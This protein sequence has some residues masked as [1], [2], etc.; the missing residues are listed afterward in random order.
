[1][2]EKIYPDYV[3]RA[4][5]NYER[6]TT[7]QSIQDANIPGVSISDKTN[8][9]SLDDKVKDV[10]VDLVYQGFTKGPRPMVYD[11]LNNRQK[12]ADYIKNNP[13]LSQ[14]ESARNRAKYLTGE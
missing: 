9:E 6:W 2:F 1:M 3:L 5:S 12:Y 14:Y 7:A 11:M 10:I 8:W 4:K 13:S